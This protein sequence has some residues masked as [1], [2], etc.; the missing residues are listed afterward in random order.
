MISCATSSN[1]CLL[2]YLY[3]SPDKLNMSSQDVW[4]I[5]CKVKHEPGPA[6]Y[7]LRGGF[8]PGLKFRS[9]QNANFTDVLKHNRSTCSRH[10]SATA[11]K[12]TAITW[13]FLLVGPSRKFY[14]SFRNWAR[15]FT[16]KFTLGIKKKVKKKIRGWAEAPQPPP[17]MN[18][19]RE[20]KALLKSLQRDVFDP[21]TDTEVTLSMPGQWFF[22]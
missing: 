17:P 22:P 12:M 16:P 11:E 6:A 14:P 21:R 19:I 5:V 3:D 10:F 2:N 18:N 1:N 15:I 8:Q 9:A 4:N 13:I 20:L 7:R